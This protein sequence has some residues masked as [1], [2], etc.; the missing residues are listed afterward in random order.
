MPSSTLCSVRS[1]SIS[2]FCLLC[3]G[4]SFY[5]FHIDK[6]MGVKRQGWLR[7]GLLGC[8]EGRIIPPT[9]PLPLPLLFL[10]A[11]SLGHFGPWRPK[12]LSTP[13]AHGKGHTCLSP[14]FKVLC[15]CRHATRTNFWERTTA[16][17]HSPSQPHEPLGLLW[18][19]TLILNPSLA[20]LLLVHP[21]PLILLTLTPQVLTLW[22]AMDRPSAVCAALC[23]SRTTFSE[24]PADWKLRSCSLLKAQAY[25]NQD[26]RVD[27]HGPWACDVWHGQQWTHTRSSM[28]RRLAGRMDVIPTVARPHQDSGP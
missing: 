6:S 4:P 17:V 5:S 28:S 20:Q 14:M 22:A 9:P 1:I 8:W 23:S 26:T 10:S 13:T 25:G 18:W 16:P 11:T 3:G 19:C 15:V 2:I 24:R 21:Q 27:P 12:F 7:F